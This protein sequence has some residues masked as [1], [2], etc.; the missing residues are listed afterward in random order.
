M[1]VIKFAKFWDI[2]LYSVPF[3]MVTI[4]LFHIAAKSVK[5]VIFCASYLNFIFEVT[6]VSH[7]WFFP[8]IQ[9]S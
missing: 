4:P 8:Q 3:T 5:S 9:Q 7:Q 6:E 1:L 2:S